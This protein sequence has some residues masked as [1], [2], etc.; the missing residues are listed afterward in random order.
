MFRSSTNNP[1]IPTGGINSGAFVKI[2][3]EDSAPGAG[4]RFGGLLGSTVV[5]SNATA[6]KASKTSV[7]TLFEGVYQIA[8]FSPGVTNVLRGQLLFW[9]T[10]A[11]NGIN[12]F[13]VT[14]VAAAGLPRAGVCL[15]DEN[16]V[17]G[18]FT[19]IQVYGLASMLYANAAVGALGAKVIQATAVDVPLLTVNT[20]NTF[21]DAT[22]I[23]TLGVGTLMKSWVGMAYETPAQNAVR[24]VLMEPNAFYY[25]IA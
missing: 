19:Y 13:L 4:D 25:N 14:N 23:G 20:V 22:Q 7:G 1:W 2:G 8:K 24:R 15:F 16:S 11:N 9:D 17:G 6:L 21:A 5:K 3:G 10:L 18:K 12:N